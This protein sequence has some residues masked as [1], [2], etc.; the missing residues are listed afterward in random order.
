MHLQAVDGRSEHLDQEA[1]SD[2][3]DSGEAGR[4]H[5]KHRS[6]RGKAEG[7]GDSGLCGF[8]IIL[9]F[10]LC[11]NDSQILRRAAASRKSNQQTT[12]SQK[13]MFSSS[14]S[15]ARLL[16]PLTLCALAVVRDA[17]DASPHTPARVANTVPV[18]HSAH[19]PGA[20]ESGTNRGS[21]SAMID[22]AYNKNLE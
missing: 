4:E 2:Q 17:R 6:H 15:F 21:Q 11:Y 13:L 8:L 7:S 5:G 14:Q 3:A 9:I 12:A 16:C 20:T 1:V 22:L 10:F 18:W 19:M